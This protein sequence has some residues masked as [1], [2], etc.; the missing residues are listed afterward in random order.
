MNQR[1]AAPLRFTTLLIFANCLFWLIF[2]IDFRSRTY[3]YKPHPPV[4]EE[5]APPYIFWG[6]AFPTFEY[7]NSVMRTAHLVQWPSFYAAIPLN[8]YFSRRGIVV[9]HQ[10]GGISVGGYY[11]VAVCL[12]S[13]LQWYLI[14][15]F[16]DWIRHRLTHTPRPDAVEIKP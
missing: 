12:L 14:G 5:Q 4:F 6:R 13:F 16:I 8:F 2:A 15:L 1:I 10:Y 7:L 9:D 3:P 11:L